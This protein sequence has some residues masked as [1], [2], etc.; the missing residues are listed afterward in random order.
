MKKIKEYVKQHGLVGTII[1][2]CKGILYVF[3]LILFGIPVKER[4]E[5]KR[6]KTVRTT[7]L[8]YENWKQTWNDNNDPFYMLFNETYNFIKE[9]ERK[10]KK[11]NFWVKTAFVLISMIFL[12]SFIAFMIWNSL[13]TGNQSAGG[14]TANPTVEYSLLLIAVVILVSLVSKWS[15]IKK[16]QETWLR[17]Q[18]HKFKLDMEM[19]KFVKNER[20]YSYVSSYKEKKDIF[21]KRVIEIWEDNQGKFEN[22]MKKESSLTDIF[23]RIAGK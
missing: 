14:S 20:P 12:L 3:G 23:N 7:E 17:H 13:H 2:L 8:I 11:K 5:R 1:E 6:T 19:L 22:N 16:Y 9:K 4:R 21:R 18:G 15:D 10:N